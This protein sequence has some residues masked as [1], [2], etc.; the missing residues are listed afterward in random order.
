[1]KFSIIIP[2]L[3]A[4]RTLENC[5]T[6]VTATDYP[7][8]QYEVLCVDNG[9]TDGS[10][11]IIQKFKTVHLIFER[12][13]Q[14][15][16]AARNAGIRAAKGE[17]IAFTDADCIVPSN[18]LSQVETA[19]SD[20]SVGA[21]AGQVLPVEPT[22]FI[23]RYQ[24]SRRALDLEVM[25]FFPF[26][27]LPITA[28][29]AYRREIFTKIGLFRGDLISCGDFELGQRIKEHSSYTIAVRLDIAVKHHH[30]TSLR[31]MLR[32]HMRYGI[33]RRHMDELKVFPEPVAYPQRNPLVYAGL[34]FLKS[35]WLSM[36]TL[37]SPWYKGQRITEL[38]FLWLDYINELTM[39]IGY[40]RA[41]KIMLAD[42]KVKP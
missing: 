42:A 9:S 21:V 25:S 19:F 18:W 32:Q 28:N 38:Q 23:E 8:D 12:T 13:R 39:R 27:W 37:F 35:S 1:M 24:V 15:S 11:R 6:S 36:K 30:R 31:A 33:G 4:E 2:V 3:N 16:Y 22:T 5:L 41:P 10:V 7:A 26:R 40:A 17:I 20:P 14:S 29:A 34:H